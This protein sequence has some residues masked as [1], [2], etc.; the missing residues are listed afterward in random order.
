MTDP[1]YLPAEILSQAIAARKVSCAEVMAAFLD[2]IER[3]NPAI[4]AIVSL[5]PRDELMAEAQAADA[6]P[7]RGP[8]HGFPFAIKDLVETAGIRTTHGSPLFADHVPTSDDLL[9]A[10]IRAAGAILIGKTNTPEFGLGSHSYNPVHGVTRNPYDLSK[11]AG[12]SSGGAAAALATKL[13]PL[14]DGSDTMGSLRNPAAFCNVYGFRPSYGRIARD[15]VGDLFLNQISMDGPMAR[16]IRDLAMLMD[17]IAGPAE[18]DP[19]GLPSHPSFLA[20]LDEPSGARR[21]GWIGDWAGHFAIEKEVL[22]LCEGA[23]GVFE[24]AGIVV[25]HVTPPFDPQRMW[26]AWLTLR[27]FANAASKRHLYEDPSSRALLKPELVYEIESGL[28]V[29]AMEVHE[30]SVVRSEWFSAAAKLFEDYDAL[31]LPSAQLLPFDAELRWPESVAGR[32]MT[33]YHQWMEVVVPASI[34]GL[35]ALNVPVG[36]SKAGL[37]MGMQLIGPRSADAAV[38]QLGDV[39]HQ[40]T[41]W[42][43]RHPPR[44][45][46]EAHA[47]THSVHG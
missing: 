21:I 37:P 4:N 17:V 15:A 5:R 43:G 25:E 14:A 3:L 23:L 38:L 34:A 31:V 32:R 22:E 10:R 36:F 33:T 9:A 20:L 26:H 42:P 40:V 29:S 41:D 45:E 13:V 19:H 8:L 35:P 27:S 24:D 39:Y 44:L 28:A 1:T 46:A 11:T 30:A 6:A 12:G 47:Q 2:R 7:R 16:S 18:H